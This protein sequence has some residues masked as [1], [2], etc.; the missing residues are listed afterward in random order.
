MHFNSEFFW[1][2]KQLNKIDSAKLFSS[3]WSVFT[4]KQ[5]FGDI[6][7]RKCR[8]Q[9]SLF[10]FSRKEILSD[11]PAMCWA[12]VRWWSWASSSG[13]I[14]DYNYWKFQKYLCHRSRDTQGLFWIPLK[15]RSN[16][17][18]LKYGSRKSWKILNLIGIWKSAD[19]SYV[20]RPLLVYFDWSFNFSEGTALHHEKKQR[21]SV[22]L[23][24]L[25]LTPLIVRTNLVLPKYQYYI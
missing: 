15:K 11:V 8:D 25:T 13:H 14:V 17:P 21:N 19:L 5:K 4:L 1:A 7:S 20:S 12:V 18:R 10:H 24:S 9:S 6:Y 3:N 23:R 2:T 22:P 16:E